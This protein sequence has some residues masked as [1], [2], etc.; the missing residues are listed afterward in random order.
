MATIET[1]NIIPRF[2]FWNPSTWAIPELYWDTF[3]NEQ[4]I[5]A[6]CKQLGKVIAYA[7][8]LGVNVDDIATRL[9]AI[10][11]G[12][13]DP[14]IVAAIEEWFEENEPSIVAAIESLNAALP[15]EDFDETNTVKDYIDALNAA[16]PISEF[17]ENNTVKEYIDTANATLQGDITAIEGIIPASSFDNVNTV[18]AYIDAAYTTINGK[19]DDI[20][21]TAWIQPS[22]LSDAVKE[23]HSA[24]RNY[25]QKVYI[26]IANGDDDTG[27]INDID[28]PFKTLPAAFK[29]LNDETNIYDFRF[30]RSG[31]YYFPRR[32]FSGASIHF[33]SQCE[34][35]DTGNITILPDPS[36]PAPLSPDEGFFFYDTH[37]NFIGSQKNRIV[38]NS[39]N[40]MIEIEG[41][42]LFASW[43]TITC[44]YLYLIQGAANIAHCVLN[45]YL[46]SKFA[47]VHIYGLDIYNSVAYSAIEF[48]CGVLRITV[49]DGDSLY[50]HRNTDAGAV[51][52]PAIYVESA[53][54]ATYAY[55]GGDDYTGYSMYFDARNSI[56]SAPD[57]T[58][59]RWDAL[60]NAASSNFSTYTVRVASGYVV[61]TS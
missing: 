43:T 40:R 30:L 53:R 35:D 19:L 9:K 18:K 4:R 11:D 5:H 59:A 38:F 29:A 14:I 61:L 32:I 52:F 56:V 1:G 48:S 60:H 49:A 51:N 57:A 8:Y 15:V 39:G 23:M 21:N 27:K 34:D 2:T 6:I 45:G 10:E 58:V 3:S 26:D 22:N 54:V 33:R 41:S 31:T 28:Y 47:N 36:I 44:A 13:L 16:L 42:T 20:E 7:D 46:K 37:L 17:D 24:S 12:Q 25:F 50:I 55:M